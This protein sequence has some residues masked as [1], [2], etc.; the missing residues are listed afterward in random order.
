MTQAHF[1]PVPSRSSNKNRIG[2]IGNYKNI[3]VMEENFVKMEEFTEMTKSTCLIK[4]GIRIT[5]NIYG[6][7][8]E[9]G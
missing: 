7:F 9:N 8:T 5:R 3:P 6:L 4:E 2:R 1:P